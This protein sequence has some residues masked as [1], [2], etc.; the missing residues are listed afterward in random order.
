MRLKRNMTEV[1]KILK[2]EEQVS[3]ELLAEPSKRELP[4]AGQGVSEADKWR[5]L[6]SAAF[7]LV[8]RAGS[9]LETAARAGG[10]GRAQKGD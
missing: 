5:V 9:E 8:F 1:C 4:E 3:G 10:Q 2:A 6:Q 7:S